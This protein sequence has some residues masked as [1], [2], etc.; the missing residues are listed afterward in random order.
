MRWLNRRLFPPW[1]LFQYSLS[2]EKHGQQTS[3]L[4]WPLIVKMFVSRGHCF[5]RYDTFP[6][7]LLAV[8]GNG[9]WRSLHAE[10]RDL[11][12]RIQ[13][14]LTTRRILRQLQLHHCHESQRRRDADKCWTW[15][16]PT[17]TALQIRHLPP[18]F[19]NRKKKETNTENFFLLK[20]KVNAR[21]F[22]R[23]VYINVVMLLCQSKRQHLKISL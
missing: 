13:I 3:V 12:Q 21:H 16:C 20:V 22:T 15:A 9:T 18:Q 4:V 5:S 7:L 19:L 10:Q 1:P 23:L 8:M 17:H 2:G 6:Y 11:S 14:H